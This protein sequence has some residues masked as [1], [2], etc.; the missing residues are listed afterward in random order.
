[1]AETSPPAAE[2]RSRFETVTLVEPIQRGE[3]TIEQITLRKP[4]AGELRGL[5]LQ[6]LISVDIVAILELLPRITDPVLLK[7][8]CDQLDPA[9]LTEIGGA[10]RGFFMTAAE[11][12]MLEAMLAEQR[13]K[14]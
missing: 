9:D 5:N 7:S 8:D 2:N 4:R 10:I 1:M 11:R 6:Q 13:P 3:T 14:T 12:Q